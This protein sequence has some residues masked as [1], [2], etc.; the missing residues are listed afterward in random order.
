LDPET[1]AYTL[2]EH[3]Q[4]TDPEPEAF[5]IRVVAELLGIEPGVR[6][7][8]V[9]LLMTDLKEEIAR[10]EDARYAHATIALIE[11]IEQDWRNER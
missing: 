11:N 5:L 4:D 1:L 2:V 7:R 6:T 8:F 10:R 3:A 9:E